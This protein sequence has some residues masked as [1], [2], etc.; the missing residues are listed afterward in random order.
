MHIVLVHIHVKPEAIEDFKKVTIDN[1]RNSIKEPGIFQFDCLQQAE[2][3]CR[4]TLVEAYRTPE[5][6]LLHRETKHYQAWKDAVGDMQAEP[7]QG[8]KYVNVYPD[9]AE[10]N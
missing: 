9:D 7:R 4:F 3:P 6:Q 8:I 5:D 1:A 2:D 10:W